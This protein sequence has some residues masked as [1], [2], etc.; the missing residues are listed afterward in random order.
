MNSLL[1]ILIQGSYNTHWL[2]SGSCKSRSF[3]IAWSWMKVDFIIPFV[4][5][6]EWRRNYT[7]SLN[8]AVTKELDVTLNADFLFCKNYRTIPGKTRHQLLFIYLFTPEMHI[9]RANR[10]IQ[11]FDAYERNS[12]PQRDRFGKSALHWQCQLEKGVCI[13]SWLKDGWEKP[14]L[15]APSSLEP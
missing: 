14:D 7:T 13:L 3:V 4:R 5:L 9:G 8:R 6:N 12:F 10:H 1:L 11:C 15:P 2:C